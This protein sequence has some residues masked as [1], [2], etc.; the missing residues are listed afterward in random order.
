MAWM[1]AVQGPSV[2]TLPNIGRTITTPPSRRLFWI[3]VTMALRGQAPAALDA[4]GPTLGEGA[5][6][7][8][9]VGVARLGR[10][11][12]SHADALL[13]DLAVAELREALGR[14]QHAGDRPFVPCPGQRREIR[15][16]GLR[17][18]GRPEAGL[19]SH[20]AI[21]VTGRDDT[22]PMAALQSGRVGL[23]PERLGRGEIAPRHGLLDLE[24]PS[25]PGE[26][27]VGAD[28]V[29]G[30]RV[31]HRRRQQHRAESRDDRWDQQAE[32]AARPELPHDFLHA[33]SITQGR[34]H[35]ERIDKTEGYGS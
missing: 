34:Y 13:D 21:G 14:D 5:E 25:L 30:A 6:V 7:L 31:P 27:G 22:F 12:A 3:T 18:R 10:D 35:P 9:R 4:R 17:D 1:W 32:P 29:V 28:G 24:E 2:S 8:L 20:G 15:L 11:P 26:L 23:A 19:R 16:P 33:R